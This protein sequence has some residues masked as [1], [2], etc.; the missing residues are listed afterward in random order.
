[1]TTRTIERRDLPDSTRCRNCWENV[2]LDRMTV[3]GRYACDCGR[4]VIIISENKPR[5]Y[6]LAG[7]KDYMTAAKRCQDCNSQLDFP[8]IFTKDNLEYDRI[9]TCSCGMTRVVFL[10]PINIHLDRALSENEYKCEECDHVFS[11]TVGPDVET[12]CPCGHVTLKYRSSRLWSNIND[13]TQ[14]HSWSYRYEHRDDEDDGTD[15][16]VIKWRHL[17]KITIRPKGYNN[18]AYIRE[19]D[20]I[21][22]INCCN[23]NNVSGRIENAILNIARGIIKGKNPAFKKVLGNY[24]LR[25]SDVGYYSRDYTS[26]RH[27]IGFDTENNIIEISEKQGFIRME[28][29][30][31]EQNINIL[32]FGE[33]PNCGEYSGKLEECLSYIV[34]S[35]GDLAETVDAG[36]VVSD[37][38]TGVPISSLNDFRTD[39]GYLRIA[40]CYY[41]RAPSNNREIFMRRY[42]NNNGHI[43]DVIYFTHRREI[44][45]VFEHCRDND[46]NWALFQQAV[47]DEETLISLAG[48]RD[49]IE[50][51]EGRPVV[52]D[53]MRQMDSKYRNDIIRQQGRDKCI[54][55]SG[56]IHSI[57]AY[58]ALPIEPVL[59]DEQQR[60][61][62]LCCSC[63]N[64][65]GDDIHEYKK[66]LPKD[67]K[68]LREIKKN[69]ALEEI[70]AEVANS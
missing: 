47:A 26:H 59:E 22:D 29:N 16:K 9:Y 2:S 58:N 11:K 62:V 36:E 14:N 43:H 24:F 66:N 69:G 10:T 27:Y 18:P 35:L 55:C 31:I 51:N 67:L 65:Y 53:M 33:R 3:P 12:T 40:D 21:M 42:Q 57:A 44:K 4:E 32:N 45:S 38:W 5:L 7:K 39:Y 1:M 68:L 28:Y 63:F 56:K 52:Q 64:K 60:F 6:E 15:D 30:P 13:S 49:R 48:S 70:V 54:L 50:D 37:E 17:T 20:Y 46:D 25:E 34:T 19:G 61:G 8:N 41:I 23:V